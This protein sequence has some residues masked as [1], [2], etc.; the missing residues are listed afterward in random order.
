MSELTTTN[1]YIPFLQDIL[2]RIQ[3]ARYKMLKSVSKQTVLL[4]RDIGRSVS[5]KAQSQWRGNAVVEQLSQDLQ[6]EFP[7]IRWFSPSNIWRMK[8][9]YE[10]YKD[11]EKLVPLVRE[12]GWVQNTMIIEKCKN[13]LER[14]YY[15]KKTKQMGRSKLDLKDKIS[16]NF[17]HNQAL[18]QHNFDDTI[19]E[20]LKWKVA[21]EFVDD[22]NVELINPDQPISEK[23]IENSIVSN[24]VHFL[25]EMGGS[26]AF[27]GR[28]YKI[29][30]EEKEYFIDLL[31]FNVKLNCYIVFELKAREF[32]PRDMWQLQMYMQLVN[33][34]IKQSQHNPSIGIIICKDKNRTVVEYMLE[35]TKTPVGV[36]TYN[37]YKDLPS[38]YAQ[39][40]P[41]EDEI[42]KRL[43]GL[44]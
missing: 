25:S 8:S 43:V 26:F 37:N 42:L 34:Q 19:S 30:L 15:L 40:L 14:E 1:G 4:Y 20:D 17:F 24:I 5:E 18:A 39:Y 2:S 12:I 28:Q 35:Q 33:K 38:E 6:R 9:F 3:S 21:R 13:D 36:A 32:D 16:T 22:Y 11:N 44:N 23:E 10:T 7:G 31:F 29:E 41:N 27:V